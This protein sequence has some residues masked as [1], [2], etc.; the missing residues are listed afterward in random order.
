MGSPAMPSYVVPMAL[1]PH[2]K[3]FTLVIYN[4]PHWSLSPF[5]PP[6][7]VYCYFLYTLTT[8]L[9]VCVSFGLRRFPLLFLKH[10]H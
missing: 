10:W 4:D 5:L 3:W 7:S 6:R 8:C 2:A 1:L 9:Q